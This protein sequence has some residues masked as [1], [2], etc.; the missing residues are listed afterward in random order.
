MQHPF[1]SSS[2]FIINL[3][4]ARAR[5][6]LKFDLAV[7]HCTIIDNDGLADLVD[8][9]SGRLH[10]AKAAVTAA[11]IELMPL[12]LA[13]RHDML[14]IIDKSTV[15]YADDAF[16]ISLDT[17]ELNTA[18]ANLRQP[19]YNAMIEAMRLLMSMHTFRWATMP[20]L[21]RPI[22]TRMVLKSKIRSD[23]WLFR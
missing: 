16:T 22:S 19:M 14:P 15:T 21:T 18:E 9:Y 17:S 7:G 20:S 2:V 1:P 4:A 23:H 8:S 5:A 10:H 11:G 3:S 13:G 12:R 6:D